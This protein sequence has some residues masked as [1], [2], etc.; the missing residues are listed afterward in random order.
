M[1]SGRLFDYGNGSH[2]GPMARAD[3][4]YTLWRTVFR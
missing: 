2:R 1:K 4:C 3:M